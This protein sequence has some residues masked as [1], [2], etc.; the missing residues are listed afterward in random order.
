MTA[1][2][3]PVTAT[4]VYQLYI[5]ASQEQVW[6]AIT[7]PAV[8]ARFFHGAQIESTY[9]V[10][11]KLRSLSPD[12]SQVWGDNT[13]LECDPPRRLVHTWRSLYDPDMAAEA[14]SRVTWEIEAQP[15]NFSRLTLIH[16]RLDDSPKTAA[17]V[18]GWS[19]ILSNLKTVIETGEALP[20]IM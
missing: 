14:D 9:E 17:S 3:E 1:A 10:G 20:P 4:Q 12:R 2:T 5:K 16:D 7:N 18:R 6:D 15:G 11:S 8:V 13:I 19:Y